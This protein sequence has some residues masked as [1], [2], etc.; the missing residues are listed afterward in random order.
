MNGFIIPKT[1]TY[2][3]NWIKTRY[4]VINDLVTIVDCSKVWKKV[5]YEMTICISKK[6]SDSPI[7]KSCV[8]KNSNILSIG[9]INK[10]LCEEFGFILNGISEEE[11]SIALKIK[12]N[13][14]SLNEIIRNRRGGMLQGKIRNTGDIKVIGGKQ[15][16]RYSISKDIKGKIARSE[17]FDVN[18]R[19]KAN[20]I[21]TQNI[22]AHIANPIPHIKII[23][24][25][26]NT[27]VNLDNYVIL[28]T[29]NQIENVSNYDTKFILGVL[30]SALISWYSYRFIFANAIRTMHFD[31]PVTKKIPFCKLDLNERS[32][33]IKYDKIC[34]AVNVLI[35]LN[36]EIATAKTPQEKTAL[37]RQIDALD[38]QI[39]QLVYQ[40]YG[41]TE[42]EIRIVEG[43]AN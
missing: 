35:K 16:N 11:I 34:E 5:K 24:T 25:L 27:L 12:R 21:I 13:G 36:K 43:E 7:F 40:L 18:S 9:L 4:E 29:V 30:N 3:S 22:V 39:D 42:E 1:F 37:Q 23:S 20:A 33:K 38:K 41:L 15:I 32:D 10:S 26:T 31:S 17:I 28:D 19:L 8:R 14:I 6:E 2:A